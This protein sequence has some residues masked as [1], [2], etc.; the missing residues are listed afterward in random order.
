MLLSLCISAASIGPPTVSSNQLD[1]YAFD[2]ET[3]KSQC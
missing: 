1:D 2:T 3:L